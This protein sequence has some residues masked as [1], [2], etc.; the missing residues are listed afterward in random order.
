MGAEKPSSVFLFTP[1][2]GGAGKGAL[3]ADGMA[4]AGGIG[5]VLT[6]FGASGVGAAL[7]V[8]GA[9][10][11][12]ISGAMPSR[13]CFETLVASGRVTAESG[14]RSVGEAATGA[15][16]T[17]TGT[18]TGAAATGAGAGTSSSSQKGVKLSA[19]RSA[20][21]TLSGAEDGGPLPG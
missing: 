20:S 14:L 19:S 11:T 9:A 12:A 1:V 21:S 15:G 8:A 10:G 2:A 13:V 6:S 3:A 18:G 5:C 4:V 16:T 7:G 17:A